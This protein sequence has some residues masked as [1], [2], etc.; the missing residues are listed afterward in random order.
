[1]KIFNIPGVLQTYN[2]KQVK[3]KQGVAGVQSKMDQMQVSTEAQLMSKVFQAAK[4]APEI[5]EDKVKH[6][7][8]LINQ[9]TYDVS[10]EA[11]AEKML[12]GINFD[13]KI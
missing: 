1:M 9:G 7:K 13:D 6:F 5:R 3:R 8:N 10:A 12:K 11:V 4:N 2:Q